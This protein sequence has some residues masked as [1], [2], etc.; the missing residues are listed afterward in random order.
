MTGDPKRPAAT[1]PKRRARAGAG[2]VHVAIKHRTWAEQYAEGK[3]LRAACPRSAHAAWKAPRDRR[4]AVEL[5][6][7]AEKGRMPDLLPLRA[8]HLALQAPDSAQGLEGLR[9]AGVRRGR[10]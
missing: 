2:P 7:A 3:A 10:H 1:A 6:L 9:L 5:V 4:D 8:N